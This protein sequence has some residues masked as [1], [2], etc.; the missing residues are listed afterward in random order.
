MP[1]SRA[2]YLRRL[3]SRCHDGKHAYSSERMAELVAE[4]MAAEGKPVN[5]Y[6]C[7]FSGD[8]NGGDHWHVGRTRRRP[9]GETE[10]TAQV[11]DLPGTGLVQDERLESRPAEEQ[12]ADICLP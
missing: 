5:V 2:A 4:S 12:A 3:K 10:E 6:H 8:E 9:P 7:P 1:R 11:L